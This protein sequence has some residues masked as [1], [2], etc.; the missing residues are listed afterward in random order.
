MVLSTAYTTLGIRIEAK[1]QHVELS[2]RRKGQGLPVHVSDNIA[3]MILTLPPSGYGQVLRAQQQHVSSSD[4]EH[5]I[6]G[7]FRDL[8]ESPGVTRNRNV[9]KH[10]L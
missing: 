9:I 2:I 4:G 8:A 10:K 6:L 5:I 3:V 7:V 1:I